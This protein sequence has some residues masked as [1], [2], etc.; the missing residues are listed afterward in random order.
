MSDT[1]LPGRLGNDAATL[2]TDERADPRI[3][4]LFAGAETIVPGLAPMASDASYEDCLAYC[5]ATEEAS[6]GQNEALRTNLPP[7]HSVSSATETIR[8]VDG[9]EIS[10][11]VDRP[12]AGSG[13]RPCIVHLHGGGMVIGSAEDPLTV[14]W[15]KSFAD[16]GL[17]VVGVQF[18][19]GGGR[20]GNHPFP[21]G[22]NDC[23]SAVR[24]VHANRERLGVSTI[25]VSGESGG[26]NLSL[27]TALKANRE[28]WID[29]IDGVYALCPY[30][31]GRYANPPADLPSL[32]END[33]YAGM[34][35]SMMAGL[36]R[37]YD[38]GGAP[39]SDPL[40]AAPGHGGR[41]GRPAAPYRVGQ[42]T[43]SAARR[44]TCLLPE[45][46]GRGN[47]GGR[48]D[49]ARHE[50]RG[51]HDARPGARDCQRDPALGSR[52]RPVPVAVPTTD[53]GCLP[54]SA[55]AARGAR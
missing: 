4:A 54:H 50:P 44:R 46:G 51:R 14:V 52:F 38:K 55:A 8:G 33:G 21:A 43:R 12:A 34:F 31:S 15:R 39:R 11:F 16:R 25:V 49:G 23:A 45:A 13:P 6:D 10:L 48:A 7:F 17:V 26:G 28:G 3:R 41:P 30:I 32:R 9:N 53:T 37:V 29:C 27:A 20:L 47:P 24:W 36:A 2:A 42:R 19:N 1:Y 5:L 40:A 22:L 35:C 18:R